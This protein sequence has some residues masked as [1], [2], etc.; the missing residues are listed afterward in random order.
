MLRF[1]LEMLTLKSVLCTC[2]QTPTRLR[3]AEAPPPGRFDGGVISPI[4]LWLT[5]QPV[6]ALCPPETLI[7]VLHNELRDGDISAKHRDICCN[8]VTLS[9]TGD[10]VTLKDSALSFW[11]IVRYIPDAIR[12]FN[13]EVN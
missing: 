12:G 9:I 7:V 10:I 5:T 4:G 1:E 8:A 3:Q 2:K 6:K 11:P 13:A